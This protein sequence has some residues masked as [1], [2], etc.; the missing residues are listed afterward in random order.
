MRFSRVALLVL[1]LVLVVAGST[2]APAAAATCP[3]GQCKTNSDCNN[4]CCAVL[5]YCPPYPAGDSPTCRNATPT[6]CGRCYC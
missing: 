1:A 4:F 3:S 5:L 2:L 6:A